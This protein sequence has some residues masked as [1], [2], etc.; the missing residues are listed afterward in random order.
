MK[1]RCR[2]ADRPG[3]RAALITN[4]LLTKALNESRSNTTLGKEYYLSDYSNATSLFS[5]SRP[6][7]IAISPYGTGRSKIGEYDPSLPGSL[8]ILKT[9]LNSSQFDPELWYT[10]ISPGSTHL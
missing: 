3:R 8:S 9:E 5:D 1:L 2:L 4:W 6:D 7:S 10:D